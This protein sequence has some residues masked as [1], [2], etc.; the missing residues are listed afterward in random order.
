M[1]IKTPEQ[2]LQDSLTNNSFSIED[3]DRALR[4]T[5]DHS[6]SY[7]YRLQRNMAI[8][9]EYFYTTRNVIDERDY[10]DFFMDYRERICAN[11]P[12][13]LIPT[14]FREKFRTSP[15]YGEAIRYEDI[16]K[17]HSLFTRLPIIIIDNQVVRTFKFHVSDDFITVH[18]GFDR[19]FLHEKKFDNDRWEYFF[20]S[21]DVS[22]QVVNN[23]YFTDFTTNTGMLQ[24]NSYDGHSYDRLLMSYLEN[25]NFKLREDGQYFAVIFLGDEKLG[26][27]L[28]EVN[29]DSDGNLVI[30]YDMDARAKIESYTG[31]VMIR[32]YFYRHLHKYTSFRDN[33][34]Q[35]SKLVRTQLV[36]GEVVSDTFIIQ[37]EESERPLPLPVPT[38]NILIF[39]TGGVDEVHQTYKSPTHF[40]N[41]NVSVLYPNFYNVTSDA[42]LGDMF[43]VYYFYIPPYDLTYDYM[44]QFFCDA[45]KYMWE[46]LTVE[47]IV[48]VVKLGDFTLIPSWSD[49]GHYTLDQMIMLTSAY[50]AKQLVASG[51]VREDLE[52]D[53]YY[54]I[55]GQAAT[56]VDNLESIKTACIELLA[57]IPLPEPPEPDSGDG[58]DNTSLDDGISLLEDPDS[59]IGTPPGI[60]EFSE[61]FANVFDFV[62]NHPIVDYYYDEVDYLRKYSDE[63]FA[64]QYKVDKLK[65]FIKDDYK[66][67]LNYVRA[68]NKVG[69]KYEFA[70]NT[71]DLEARY[72]TAREDGNPFKEPMYMF[73]IQK[74]D[75]GN[76][77][78]ARIFIDGLMC[79]TFALER[80]EF[81]DIFYI[82][83]HYITE[84]SYIEIEV[85]HYYEAKHTYVFTEEKPYVE[86]EFPPKQFIRPT[87]SD[88]YFYPGTQENLIRF[89]KDKFDLEYISDR[90]NYYVDENTPIAIFYKKCPHGDAA[91]GPY[92]DVNGHCFTFEG[93][94][95]PK[96]DI[97]AD[98]VSTMLS[99]GDLVEEVGYETDNH[100]TIVKLE[101]VV[102]Y[103]RV[104]LGETTLQ[105]EDNKGLL[106]SNIERV[107]I[108][109]NDP[110][111]YDQEITI[112]IQKRPMFRGNK[113]YRVEYPQYSTPIPN[114]QDAEEYTRAF[115]NGRLMSKN[116][117]DFTDYFDGI[118]GIQILEKLVRGDT[119]GFDITP[120]RN[121]LIY[122]KEELDSYDIDLRG[123]INKPFDPKFYEVYLNGRRLN[124]TNI[125]PIGPW[126]IRLAG[127]HSIYHL[128]IYEKDRDWEYYGVHFS[129]YYT[130]SDL[131]REPFIDP[132]I[133]EKL[134][135]GITGGG[136]P[137][138]VIDEEKEPWER[139]FDL[140]SVFF[141]IFYYMKL[142]PMKF[143]TGDK[144]Q[145]STEEIAKRYP[146]IYDLY[147]TVNDNGNHVLFL[148]P[149]IYYE[150]PDDPIGG[151]FVNHSLDPEEPEDGDDE[152]VQEKEKRWRV[153]L[154]GN[155]D[156]DD[157]DSPVDPETD[158]WEGD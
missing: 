24:R 135:D 51:L 48:N 125:Y 75:P 110:E 12:I 98:E 33:G 39:K 129:N 65:T 106:C 57:N 119:I 71:I 35:N 148:N 9:E 122:Y 138:N 23:S 130:I 53:A 99:N 114:F 40:P 85:F 54:Y 102:T 4:M 5:L 132:E 46:K 88:L 158:Y 17:D 84:D 96:N 26:T 37:N 150:A 63:I 69:F 14:Q 29:V 116:R 47:Q 127:L 28:L 107:R 100:L 41:S 113:K 27:N 32:L 152:E 92:Y 154:L 80:Y 153:Y 115:K 31:S 144:E 43:K 149:N 60:P 112:G 83:A 67:L 146:I 20:I 95:D 82:P 157:L 55:Y 34:Y 89:D 87:M 142:I 143:V 124:R 128:E 140:Y 90:Y 126:E 109:L 156:T 19:Y 86:L 155:R 117:Y 61:A 21:H 131:I 81:T 76:S 72:K 42:E 91:R 70:A 6:F 58:T 36:D 30:M 15:Y 79:V 97:T 10:G 104:A 108:T 49:M 105:D 59:V 25:F 139:E 1:V 73:P 77:L 134:I 3:T 141:E 94:P 2:F 120:F 38:E 123:Y 74:I 44:Y 13:T 45:L 136:L 137:P 16:N 22:V 78:S 68:Q 151:G 103:D 145:F 7:L 133:K 62:I 147:H 118:M 8:Y 50:H 93:Q 101:D 121:R 64:F 66:A 52:V 18:Y 56:G 11:Y 111:L